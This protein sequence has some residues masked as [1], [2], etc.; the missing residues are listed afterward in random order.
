MKKRTIVVNEI[1]QKPTMAVG[2][3]FIVFMFTLLSR[4]HLLIISRWQSVLLWSRDHLSLDLEK[5]PKRPTSGDGDNRSIM[6]KQKG[7]FL[8]LLLMFI[9]DPEWRASM[10][11][12]RLDNCSNRFKRKMS[13]QGRLLISFPYSQD[14]SF[15]CSLMDSNKGLLGWP[16]LSP[17]FHSCRDST[18]Y[19]MDNWSN[20]SC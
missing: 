9:G 16:L 1:R 8:F 17:S 5:N 3:I 15:G 2:P 12:W 13:D 7:C 18:L 6:R 4:D 20:I 19:R 14:N 11:R 10:H